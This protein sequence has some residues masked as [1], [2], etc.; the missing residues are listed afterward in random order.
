M[1]SLSSA[2]PSR[3]GLP[4]IEDSDLGI[5]TSSNHVAAKPR[6][7]SKASE[8]GML[9][10]PTV[11][12]NTYVDYDMEDKESGSALDKSKV[13]RSIGFHVKVLWSC[14]SVM[15]TVGCSFSLLQPHW[16]THFT[17][18]DS[19]GLYSYCVTD[20]QTASEQQVCDVY[21]GY[22]RLQHLPSNAW[23]VSCLLYGMG[24]LLLALSSLSSLMTLV[25]NDRW[26]DRI[27]IYTGYSQTLAGEYQSLTAN[28]VIQVICRGFI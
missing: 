4:A 23:Q 12:R 26:A 19:L 20:A 25:L 5:Q 11:L 7:L 15:V 27:A 24:C 18:R 21:G 3:D 17:T 13:C 10:S 14:L 6:S 2:S 22:F 1:G 8:A 16:F 28:W 9:S